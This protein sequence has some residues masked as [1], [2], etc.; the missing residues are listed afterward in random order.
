M[1][2]SPSGPV[3]GS[4]SEGRQ[5]A[6]RAST[7]TPHGAPRHEGPSHYRRKGYPDR[8]FNGK[9]ASD[10]WFLGVSWCDSA[11]LCSRLLC[12]G[13]PAPRTS[14]RGA[15][16]SALRLPSAANERATRSRIWSS[17]GA[18][19]RSCGIR[20]PPARDR[21]GSARV[22]AYVTRQVG[23][24]LVSAVTVAFT[25]TVMGAAIADRGYPSAPA[26]ARTSD[27]A[28]L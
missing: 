25:L 14:E 8:L 16:S 1:T 20:R 26:A 28:Y 11:R 22:A 15:M 3:A 23:L 18:V 21:F 4:A 13:E 9:S 6:G 24:A 10:V 27:R 5:T 17:S 2:S 12:G 7:P 19:R